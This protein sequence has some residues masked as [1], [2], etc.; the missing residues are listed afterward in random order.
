MEI[1]RQRK[2]P[3]NRKKE[4]EIIHFLKGNQKAIEEVYKYIL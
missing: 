1:K 3:E 4:I 2:N